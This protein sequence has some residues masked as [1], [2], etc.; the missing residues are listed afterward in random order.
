MAA[1]TRLAVE[2]LLRRVSAYAD[3]FQQEATR[4]GLAPPPV[5]VACVHYLAT[6][7]PDGDGIYIL[8]RS[9]ARHALMVGFA[10]GV[11]LVGGTTGAILKMAESYLEIRFP[12]SRVDSSAMYWS[13]MK[14]A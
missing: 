12:N 6:L 1:H 8:M 14:L 9:H 3:S 7:P 11:L 13:S 10:R 2:T 5:T 4:Q